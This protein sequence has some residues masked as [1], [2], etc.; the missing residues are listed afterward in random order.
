MTGLLSRLTDTITNILLLAPIVLITMTFHEFA[1]AFVSYKLGDFTAKQEGRLSLNPLKHID[2]V[3]AIFFIIFRFGWA[4]PVPVRTLYFKNPKR[5]MMLT[6]IAGPIMNLILAVVILPFYA[7]SLKY[8]SGT[9]VSFLNTFFAYFISMNIGFAVFNMIPIPPLDGSR[10]L[11]Y[12]LPDSA[13]TKVLLYER[14]SFFILMLL[15]LTGAL[16]SI[17]SAISGVI[18]IPLIWLLEAIFN[19]LP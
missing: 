12:F 19:L 15:V 17:I 10:V 9:A 6:S 3:G 7:L 1:H 8:L 16:S 18:T 11:L 13:F 2:P 4:K 5:D 14:Y